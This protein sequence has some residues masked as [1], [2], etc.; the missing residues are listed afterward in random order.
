VAVSIDRVFRDA[1]V[2]SASTP[3]TP[4][5]PHAVRTT[6][7]RAAFAVRLKLRSR[8]RQTRHDCSRS[9]ATQRMRNRRLRSARLN[10]ACFPAPKQ[11][12]AIN[13]I[14]SLHQLPEPSSKTTHPPHLR[15]R[16][17]PYPPRL[18]PAY[19]RRPIRDRQNPTKSASSL[20]PSTCPLRKKVAENPIPP[21]FTAHCHPANQV[22]MI[23]EDT[24]P[25][26]KL[27]ASSLTCPPLVRQLPADHPPL[28]RH[29]AGRAACT[30]PR[31]ADGVTLGV[32]HFLGA[33]PCSLFAS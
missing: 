24:R 21:P 19:P 2:Q 12:R 6:R 29:F 31:P 30:L 3:S 9:D 26:T 15:V 20:K 23:S 25:L 18:L 13:A 1:V 8:S 32:R 14:P 5:P 27:G 22:S 17:R 28:T 33:L 10:E 4:I 7:R 11:A 16:P